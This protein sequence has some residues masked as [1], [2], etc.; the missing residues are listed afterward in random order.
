MADQTIDQLNID[1]KVKSSSA[2]TKKVDAL[3]YSLDKLGASVDDFS[4]EKFVGISKSLAELKISS[5]LG[6]NITNL[7]DAI[8]NLDI[9]KISKKLNKLTTAITPFIDKVNSASVA[10]KSLSSILSFS[11]KGVGKGKTIGFNF[12]E[13]SGGNKFFKKLFDFTKL[14]F[15]FRW[16]KRIGNEVWKI[17]KTGADF[18]ETL[19]L[20]ETAMGNNLSKATEFVNK[21][22]K[23][24]GVSEQTLMNAQATF[25]N[26]LGALGQISDETAYVLSEGITQMALDYASLYNQSFEDAMTKFQAA[27][28]GQVRPIRSVSGFDIT[29][30]TLYPIY[31]SLGGEKTMRQLTRTEKQLLSIY[32][33]FQQMEASGTTGDL[34][35]TIESFANQTRIAQDSLNRVKQYAGVLLDYIA[36]EADLMYYIN[37]ALIFASDTLKAVAEHY[38]AIEHFQSNQDPFSEVTE[39]A[40][41]AEEA[42]EELNNKLLSFDKFQALN[43]P[44]ESSFAIDNTILSAFEKYSSILDSATL[45][46]QEFADVLKTKSGLFDEDGAFNPD[47]WG[48]LLQKIKE[49]VPTIAPVMAAFA[50]FQTGAWKLLLVFSLI[51]TAINNPE[52]SASIKRL[53]EPLAKVALALTNTVISIF[54]IVEPF[55]PVLASFFSNFLVWA[56]ESERRIR[57]IASIIVG[58]MALIK[59][60]GNIWAG[61]GAWATTALLLH[62][63]APRQFADGGL[64]DKGSLFVAGEAGAELVTNMGGGQSGVMN[65]EQLESAVTRGIVI[66][67]S[68]IDTTDNRPIYVNIDGQRFF[69]ASRDIYKR[70][71]YDLSPVR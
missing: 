59:S 20:W 52:I 49:L 31:Q 17:A 41:E 27:L 51:E 15:A 10:L 39:G 57:N 60:G 65:M 42:I 69:S 58:L 63:T 46:A 53:A 5:V 30:T 24:Y 32:A 4:A 47:R 64:P 21:L 61:L 18:T 19:N 66:G 38:Q 13:N 50:V 2:N 71:G 43:D 44:Q 1:I 26:M 48:E 11:N 8:D 14:A 35:K 62:N 67:L 16:A 7:S 40:E 9:D 54:N 36:K 70:N 29:E 12:G 37:G 25:K 33:I 22:N 55:I 3:A 45:R 68:A 28:A 34:Q 6:K 56:T 23:A